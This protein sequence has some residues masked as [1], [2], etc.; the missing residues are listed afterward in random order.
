MRVIA[1][2]SEARVPYQHHPFRMLLMQANAY[3]DL[4][5]RYQ[6]FADLE[7]KK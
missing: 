6:T 2:R 4:A 7:D 1:G 3:P 5:A